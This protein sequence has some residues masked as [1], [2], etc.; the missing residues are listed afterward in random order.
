MKP[1]TLGWAATALLTSFPL[2]AQKKDADWFQKTYDE[3][4]QETAKKP[5]KL[6]FVYCWEDG[7]EDSGSFYRH[8]LQSE[9]V[10]EAL[11]D[12]LCFSAKRDF[13]NGRAVCERYGV[14]RM[15]TTLLVR[16]SGEVE[17]VLVGY[18][19]P[20]W[21]VAELKRIRQGRETI[22]ALRDAVAGAP[23][24][25]DLQYRLAVKLRAIGDEDS[26]TSIVT[27]IREKD[28]KAKTDVGAQLALDEVI[29]EVFPGETKPED[30][31]LKPLKTFLI[32]H[33]NKRVQ[34]LGYD[35]IAA[36]EHKRGNL[37]AAAAAIKKAAKNAPEDLIMDWGN[38]IAGHAWESRGDL[39][40]GDLKLALKLAERSI[41]KAEEIDQS[42]F[43]DYAGFLAWRY[44]TFAYAQY[45]NS[46]RK[47][48]IAT[49]EKAVAL[50][51]EEKGIKAAL[52][53]FKSGSIKP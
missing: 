36:T 47:E 50:L 8:T 7:S 19:N 52:D 4:L 48:A 38:R 22:G 31:D 34:F 32:K 14:K 15:P 53:G 17:D 25:L 51:P 5:A 24:D 26:Y 37:K 11:T 35:R 39:S 2:A 12:F 40:K 3:A 29:A 16:P 21:L 9:A 6:A 20:A 41:K 49:M 27:A 10:V 33:K 46:K 13:D 23:D 30:I 42:G 45:M 44:Y 18:S 43:T 28:P 1:H